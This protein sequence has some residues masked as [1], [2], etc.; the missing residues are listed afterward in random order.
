[1][2]NKVIAPQVLKT[3]NHFRFS[4]PR[5]IGETTLQSTSAM[6]RRIMPALEV[7]QVSPYYSTIDITGSDDTKLFQKDEEELVS[8]EQYGGEA[9]HSNQV[10]EKAETE[11]KILG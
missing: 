8:S 10:I 6:P 2:L 1:M 11:C 9:I 5:L 4:T 3:R 7:N